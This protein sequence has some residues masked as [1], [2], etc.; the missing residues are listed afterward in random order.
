[1]AAFFLGVQTSLF[2]LKSLCEMMLEDDGFF[3]LWNVGKLLEVNETTSLTLECRA[4]FT[5]RFFHQR[6]FESTSKN[7]VLFMFKSS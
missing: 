6:S 4:S 5:V 3:F 2:W 7:D 1:M